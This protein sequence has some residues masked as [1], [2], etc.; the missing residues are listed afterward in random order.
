MRMPSS[1]ESTGKSAEPDRELAQNFGQ[2]R[3]LFLFGFYLEGGLLQRVSGHRKVS[4]LKAVGPEHV[5]P[6][7]R[8]HR[9]ARQYRNRLV[10][11]V[12]GIISFCELLL[13]QLYICKILLIRYCR[14]NNRHAFRLPRKGRE[15][16]HFNHIIMRLSKARV[17]DILLPH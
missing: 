11:N 8:V 10:C 17:A 7:L 1:L 6:H 5:R 3:V 13:R 9:R 16:R 15:K 12:H 2:R 4:G 14:R